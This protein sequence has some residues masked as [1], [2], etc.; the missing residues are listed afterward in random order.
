MQTLMMILLVAAS[1]VS[2]VCWI[3]I[4]VRIFKENVGLGILGIICGLFAFIYGW[5]KV[6]EYDAKNIMLI[7]TVAWIVAMIAQSL[8]AGAIVREMMSAMEG[9]AM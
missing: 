7:W 4:L 1:V 2:L 9:A 5:V 6:K 8:G 3:M